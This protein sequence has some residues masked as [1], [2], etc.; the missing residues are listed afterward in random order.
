MQ[1]GQ[2]LEAFLVIQG[3]FVC[4]FVLKPDNFDLDIYTM[5][6]RKK[7]LWKKN[8]IKFVNFIIWIVY[9]IQR[10]IILNSFANFCHL[11]DNIESIYSPLPNLLQLNFIYNVCVGVAQLWA[12]PRP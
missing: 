3:L 11:F 7:P 6:E 5:M 12:K 1:S 2:L 4:L 10:N 8:Q 9:R